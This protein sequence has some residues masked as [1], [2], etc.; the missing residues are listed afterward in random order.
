MDALLATIANRPYVMAI[1]AV[2]WVLAPLEIGWRRAAVWFVSGT[3][4]GWL[5]EYSSTRIGFPFGHYDYHDHL[6]PNELWV[7][8]VP[9]FS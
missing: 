6:F 5:A 4:L 8:G 2:F 3:L 7:G 1:V 9:P